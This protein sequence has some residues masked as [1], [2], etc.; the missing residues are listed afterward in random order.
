L[1]NK[2]LFLILISFSILSAQNSYYFQPSFYFTYGD[3]TDKSKSQQF[4]FFTTFSWNNYDYVVVG[5]DRI[6]IS[7]KSN[8]YRWDYNQNNFSGGIHYWLNDLNLK[9]KLDFV[10]VDGNYRDDYITRSLA[11]NGYLFS[12]EI[13]SGVYPFYYGGGYSYFKQQG[14][15]KIQS[16][17]IYFRTDYYPHYKI[18]LNTIFSS[19]LISDGRKQASLQVSAF[20]FPVYE[21]S[22]KG[23]FTI[24]ARSIFYNP[25]LMVLYNQLETQTSNYSLQ[26]NYNFYKNFV[27]ALQYQRANFTSYQINYFVIGIKSP[28]YF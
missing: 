10:K 20:Y 2:I 12:P 22:L 26:L 27:I 8:T 11:D 6:N 13:I 21:L 17:Q 1:S 15:S 23:S 18:L 25:D 7:N 5:Y 28:V 24:G 4:S 16:H 9:L 14:N 19:H 3:Y